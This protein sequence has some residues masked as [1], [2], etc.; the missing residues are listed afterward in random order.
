MIL[1]NKEVK[2]VNLDPENGRERG[3]LRDLFAVLK[4]LADDTWNENVDDGLE[5]LVLL[6]S[7]ELRHK[8]HLLMNLILIGIVDPQYHVRYHHEGHPG[9][10]KCSRTRYQ[11][12]IGVL[13]ND[14]QSDLQECNA[15]DHA[16]NRYKE[17]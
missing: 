5:L 9:E 17:N 11:L 2:L 13:H 14:T 15:R 6:N 12:L 4:S 16:H 3:L 10:L 1:A 8:L 7:P